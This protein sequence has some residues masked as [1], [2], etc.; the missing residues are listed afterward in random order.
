MNGPEATRIIRSFG[1]TGPIFGVTGN[2]LAEDIAI[3]KDH[4]ADDVIA[5]P[6]Q[7]KKIDE[8]WAR[9]EYEQQ[10]QQRR[11]KKKSGTS[12]EQV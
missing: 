4:G 6:V 12:T 9:F 3:F 8:R 1:Y 11:E 5:K 2:V 7:Y 10:Q